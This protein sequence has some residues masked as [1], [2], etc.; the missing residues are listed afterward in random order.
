[1]KKLL[2]SLVLVFFISISTMKAYAYYEDANTDYITE[3]HPQV[4]LSQKMMTE[5]GK[6]LVPS[7]SILGVNDVEEVVFSYRVFVQDGLKLEVEESN[8]LFNGQELGV[9]QDLFNFDY[10]I[11]VLE[12]DALHTNLFEAS[13]AGYFVEVV[14]RVSM[15][16]PSLEEYE[17]VA[18][19]A[20]TFEVIFQANQ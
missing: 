12:E 4:L 5:A 20:M 9:V 13:E 1:M 3:E 10:S 2:I 18:N 7:G 16:N 15:E 6:R 19:K 11:S 14:L 17:M 8:I